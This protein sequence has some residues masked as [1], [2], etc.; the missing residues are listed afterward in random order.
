M[1]RV[2]TEAAYGA[3]FIAF[4]MIAFWMAGAG[5]RVI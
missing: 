2:L 3:A 5:E 4:W 1:S